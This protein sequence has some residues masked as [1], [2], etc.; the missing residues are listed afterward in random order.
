MSLNRFS[1]LIR[2]ERCARDPLDMLSILKVR[3][4]LSTPARDLILRHT[5]IIFRRVSSTSLST[6]RNPALP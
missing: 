2:L 4:L 3:D 1:S 6:T 5:F